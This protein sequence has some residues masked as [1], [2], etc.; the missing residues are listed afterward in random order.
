M[1]MR[2]SKEEI[3]KDEAL[4]ESLLKTCQYEPVD[5]T[6]E[7]GFV[8]NIAVFPGSSCIAIYLNVSKEALRKDKKLRKTVA[9]WIATFRIKGEIK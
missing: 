4:I 6:H 1:D 9:K 7:K 8:A 3:M 5:G 2:P